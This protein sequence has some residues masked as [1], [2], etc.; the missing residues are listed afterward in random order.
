MT[1]SKPPLAELRERIDAIDREL[2]ELLMRRAS[3]AADVMRAKKGGPVWRPARE[4]Q[5]LRRL[6]ER[7]RGAFPLR[8]LVQIWR[9][10]VSAMTRLQGD[11]SVAA[12]TPAGDRTLRGLARDHFGCGAE[13]RPFDLA[14]DVLEA[15]KTG[16]ATAGVV[17]E[18]RE[19]GTEPWW[20]ALAADPETSI[21]AELPFAGPAGGSARTFCVARVP[22]EESGDDRSLVAFDANRKLGPGEIAS[23]ASAFAKA[24][25]RARGSCTI[26]GG[27]RHFL[28][29]GEFLAPGDDRFL[30]LAAEPPEPAEAFFHLGAWPAPLATP[31]R[32]NGSPER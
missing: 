3:V 28:E 32:A 5:V 17:G 1:T 31:D 15:V 14:S 18:P 23:V 6:A 27:H 10:I 26:A 19:P 16:A 25:W 22:L 30:R 7:H 11:F 21:C 9:E 20:S 12:H 8:S 29:C 24:E 2:H 13:I 4:A